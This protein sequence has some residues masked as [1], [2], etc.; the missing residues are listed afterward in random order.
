MQFGLKKCNILHLVAG[1][2]KEHRGRGH[3]LLSGDKFRHLRLDEKYKYLGIDE[4]G[5]IDH[6]EVRQQI[7]KEYFRRVKSVTGSQLN[8][9]NIL[10]AL[11]IYAVP[12][13]LYTF[14]IIN[15]KTADLKKI[16]VKTRKILAMNKAHQ[17][18][19]D[20][21]RLY[22]PIDQGG[23]GLTNLETLYKTQ[24][25]K[26]KSYIETEKDHILRAI[27]EHDKNKSKYS[28]F[29][30]TRSNLNEIGL[31]QNEKYT[32]KELKNAVVKT[33]IEIIKAKPLHGQF[34]KAV[35][36]KENIDRAQSF[37]WF[38]RQP[39]SPALESAIFAIQDQAVVTRQ[40]E[41]DIMKRQVDGRCRLCCI[42]DETTQ[43]IVSG[44]E[45]LAGTYY[46]KRHNNIVQ[47]V[48]WSLAKKHTFQVSDL[49][50]RE[51]LTQP[52]V[53]ENE[54]AKIMWEIAVQ[55]DVT[56]VHNRPDIIYINK[57]DNK[58][59]LIDVTVPSDYNI[60]AK[61]IEK[62]SKYHALKTEIT[63]LWKTHTEIVP[64]VIG[65]TGVIAKSLQKYLDKLDANIN[66]HIMQKQAAIH[67]VTIITKVLGDTVFVGGETEPPFP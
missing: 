16:D 15:Y 34:Y 2:R 62:L 28:I 65:A 9:R 1:R 41:R 61:E 11:N 18:K 27:V 40:H 56:I 8:A 21:D 36:E 57:T 31:Q 26:Y 17:Q 33:K 66:P 67:T 44:C 59:Y 19:A 51:H 12:V 47:Y 22:I 63:R 39:V 37:Q 35:L 52:Q 38:K 13:L 43:H 5:K 53:R 3:V 4:A 48:F 10:R 55:T 54:G 24:I 30:E 29:K 23:R 14:G 25:I 64:I 32:D 58:T 42:K 46:T 60:G 50:W 6:N 49:W 20:V 7:Q 45:K